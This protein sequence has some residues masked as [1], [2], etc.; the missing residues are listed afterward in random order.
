MTNTEKLCLQWNDF[1]DNLN[2]TFR[3]LRNDTEFFD[4]T[5][6]S[7]N[8]KQVETHKIILASSSPFFANLLKRNKHP[9]PLIYMRG[10]MEVLMALV[11]FLYNGEANVFQENLDS[12]LALAEDLRL[13]GL[14]GPPEDNASQ[15][16]KSPQRFN[17]QELKRFYRKET[18]PRKLVTSGQTLEVSS[19]I[20]IATVTNQPVN[21]Q[22]LHQLDDQIRSMME[23]TGKSMI[24]GSAKREALIC[25]V[26][27][28]EGQL[29]DVMRHIEANHITG[30]THTCDIC[31]KTSR[32]EKD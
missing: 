11:D 23:H 16:Q 32:S 30:L 27:G 20:R 29:A 8:G 22:E 5:L 17:S 2:S 13:R 4:V 7:D 18:N 21:V 31:S 24:V 6:V 3:E 15:D 10:V 19:E 26:C 25:K 1:Q 9:H 12:F 28:R 14:T